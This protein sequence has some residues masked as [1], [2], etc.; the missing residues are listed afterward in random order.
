MRTD[1]E[2][3]AIPAPRPT[4]AQLRAFMAESAHGSL[5]QRS[6]GHT[7]YRG[8]GL[9]KDVPVLHACGPLKGWPAWR[10]AVERF[11]TDR[12]L[13]NVAAPTRPGL[14]TVL[15]NTSDTP[16]LL[17]N[18]CARLGMRD[19]VILGSGVS[20]W[21][22][23]KKYLL[24]RDCLRRIRTEYVLYLDAY[25]VL[26]FADP[27]VLLERFLSYDCKLLFMGESV[28]YPRAFTEIDE[29]ER[30][31]ASREGCPPF[32]RHL[33]DGA[34]IGR[35]DYLLGILEEMDIND[36]RYH[37]QPYEWDDTPSD[38][39]DGQIFDAQLAAR[40]WYADCY[41]D[42]KLD[43]RAD[44]FIRFDTRMIAHVTDLAEAERLRP[45]NEATWW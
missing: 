2:R 20:P 6:G 39:E 40:R 1:P 27:S 12:S 37:L 23:C 45:D 7:G 32:Y 35:T 30:E 15:I 21:R 11:F 38:R 31:I 43:Y 13:V 4:A 24:L 41:P 9:S 44:L 16:S 26:L 34:F 36:D 22:M 28:P 14:S 25:D 29:R 5:R 19:H 18:V 10:Q 17:Q 42:I 33:N 3:I 8:Y